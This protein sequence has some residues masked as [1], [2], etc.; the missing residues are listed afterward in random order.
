[1]EARGIT[2]RAAGLKTLAEEAPEAY[3]DVDR[4]VTVVHGAGISRRVA[5]MTPL[6]VVKG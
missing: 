6:A 4:V 3:K 2:V 5:R 1:L